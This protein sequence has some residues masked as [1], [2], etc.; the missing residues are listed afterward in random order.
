MA[1]DEEIFKKGSTTYYWSSKFFPKK[2][3]KD[4][5]KFY[6]FVRVVDDYVH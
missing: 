5:L 3:R 4:V 2:V 6:S 1:S